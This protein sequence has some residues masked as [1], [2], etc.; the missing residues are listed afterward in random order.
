MATTAPRMNDRRLRT[1]KATGE[2]Y[3]LTTGERGLFVRV[4]AH[5]AITFAFM[6]RH[7]GRQRRMW[8]G[9][10]P[11][12]TWADAYAAYLKARGSV[13]RGTDPLAQRPAR[14]P[15]LT[16]AAF[17]T[18]HYFPKHS[19]ARLQKSSRDLDESVFRLHLA[20]LHTTPL[21]E[22]TTADVAGLVSAVKRK[23]GARTANNVRSLI[24][25]M[26]RRAQEWNLI[27]VT[28]ANP[29]AGVKRFAQHSRERFLE[30]D[31][32]PRF[33]K[34]V[35]AE[36]SPVWRDFFLLAVLTGARK[37]NLCGMRWDQLDLDAGMWVI[38]GRFTKSAKT[39]RLPLAP[40][41]VAVLKARRDRRERG[42][43]WVFPSG[44]RM[45]E[46]D[47]VGPIRDPKKAFQA[48]LERA[49]IPYGREDGVTIHD[50]RRTLGSMLYRQGASLK[51]IAEALGHA[52][53]DSTTIYARLGQDVSPLRRVVTETSEAILGPAALAGLL[54]TGGGQ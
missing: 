51:M 38:P 50:L 23:V 45:K 14:G 22:L 27:D 18:E 11:A 43:P 30:G 9:T 16:V 46:G 13:Q 1:L 29:A 6:Y 4:S 8:L 53:L 37:S 47:P 3:E 19:Q 35:A 49:E 48:I 31:E 10:Y 26:W 33:L 32:L 7:R 40:A 42:V 20:P 39:Y 41:A 28:A 44:R 25:A 12:T 34:A 24:G 2:R 5:G 54:G 17:F 21:D 36:P 52:D 15:A